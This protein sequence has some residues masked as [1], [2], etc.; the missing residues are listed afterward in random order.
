MYAAH[1]VWIQKEIDGAKQ[2]GKPILAVNPWG[3]QKKAGVVL[4]N[5]D[6]GIGW[7]KQPIINAIW[8]LYYAKNK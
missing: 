7:N 8:Q 3:Q 2:H 1:S 5:A 4:N 6:D